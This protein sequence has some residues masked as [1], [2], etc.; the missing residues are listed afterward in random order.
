M[1]KPR[2]IALLFWQSQINAT[3]SYQHG[4]PRAFME[5]PLF[6]CAPI[7]LACD[8][9]RD[10]WAIARLLWQGRFDAVVLLHSVFSNQ[11]NLRRLLLWLVSHCRQPKA[12]FIGNEYKNMPEKMRFCRD[13]GLSLL[14]SQSNDLRVHKLYNAELGC[15]VAGIPNTGFDPAVFRPTTA[16]GERKIDIGYRAYP[17]PL[18]LGNNEKAEI[19]DYFLEQAGRLGLRIDISM[20]EADRFDEAGY[21]GFLNRCRGQIGTES[22]GDYFELTDATRLRVNAYLKERPDAGWPEIKRRF[23]DGY[24]PSVPMR[25]ISGRQVEAA[26][27]KTVQILF[28]GR[29]NDMLQP[30]VHYIPLATDFSDIDEAMRKFRDDAF[31]VDVTDHAYD[32]AMTE[33]RY[34]R[35]VE[36]F[37]HALA[38][39]L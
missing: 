25:I 30:D 4:W 13:L 14:V 2:R 19:A 9:L 8:R 32:V 10:R 17:A 33:L 16:L 22:G 27:C 23:F 34:E 29:Y 26:A 36:K 35:L 38:D 20:S 7:N 3:L 28:R 18:Y 11:Q 31:C 39:V 15:R 5:S 6:D 37:S 1:T 21:A 12:F 24:G